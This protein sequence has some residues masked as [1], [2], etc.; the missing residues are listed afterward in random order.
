MTGVFGD[1]GDNDD[2]LNG[3]SLKSGVFRRN[4]ARRRP[5][6]RPGAPAPRPRRPAPLRGAIRPRAPA[7]YK[8]WRMDSRSN[9]ECRSAVVVERNNE[10]LNGTDRKSVAFR[11]NCARRRPRPWPGAP[12]PRPRRPAPPWG[13]IRP[14]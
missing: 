11:R 6:V 13:A 8:R 5:Q 12:A 7:P 4:C 1:F 14:W 2:R 3:T 9:R 10:R